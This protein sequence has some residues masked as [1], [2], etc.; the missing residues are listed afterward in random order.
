[1]PPGEDPDENELLDAIE[2]SGR[3]SKQGHTPTN[4]VNVR[5]F[6]GGI[7]RFSLDGRP[8]GDERDHAVEERRLRGAGLRG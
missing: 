7:V 2:R 5:D 6:A 3:A 8:D 1:V 4:R